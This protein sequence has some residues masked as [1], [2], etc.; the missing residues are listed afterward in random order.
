MTSSRSPHSYSLCLWRRNM[1]LFLARY[2]FQRE[3]PQQS[4]G[5]LTD[6]VLSFMLS[7]QE[8]EG[9]ILVLKDINT[10][11]KPARTCFWYNYKG[12]PHGLWKDCWWIPWNENACVARHIALLLIQDV[13]G[14]CLHSYKLG[15]LKLLLICGEAES[16]KADIPNH[17]G[18]AWLWL[19]S[20]LWLRR[21]LRSLQSPRQFLPGAWLDKFQTLPPNSSHHRW[22][23]EADSETGLL[24]TNSSSL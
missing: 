18:W 2:L 5:D 3:F 4:L 7:P 13:S 8:L 1:T 15:I 12:H 16:P 20:Q 11:K 19:Y 9:Q 22:S 6:T 10:G 21:K 23:R 24:L 14:K 17:P